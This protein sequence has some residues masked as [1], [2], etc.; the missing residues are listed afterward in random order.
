MSIVILAI[1][2]GLGVTSLVA[3]MK[4]R[5]HNRGLAKQAQKKAAAQLVEQLKKAAIPVLPYPLKEE[6]EKQDPVAEAA[7]LPTA[8]RQPVKAKKTNHKGPQPKQL[9]PRQPKGAKGK[10]I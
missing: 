2:V 8:K 7:K 6:A 1:L 9:K 10:Q 5:A 4:T 3:L